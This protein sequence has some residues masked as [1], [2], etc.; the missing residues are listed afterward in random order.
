LSGITEVP[1]GTVDAVKFEFACLERF[2]GASVDSGMGFN[3]TFKIER[4][5]AMTL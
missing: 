2:S 1:P 5:H 3:I 4:I